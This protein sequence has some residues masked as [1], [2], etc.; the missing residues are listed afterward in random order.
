MSPDQSANS[1]FSLI[2]YVF[3]IKI[4]DCIAS[5]RWCLIYHSSDQTFLTRSSIYQIGFLSRLQNIFVY[6]PFVTNFWKKPV[7]LNFLRKYEA[8]SYKITAIILKYRSMICEVYIPDTSNWALHVHVCYFS[9]LYV[10]SFDTWIIFML[11]HG[12]SSL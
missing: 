5:C 12:G 4:S 2:E 8:K 6:L 1:K 9:A 11:S 3:N 10:H 7:K